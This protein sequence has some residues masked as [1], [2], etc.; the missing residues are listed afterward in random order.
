MKEKTF[1]ME[2]TLVK[3]K[4]ELNKEKLFDLWKSGV[5]VLEEMLQA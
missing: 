1:L 4:L 2:V 5:N 3:L